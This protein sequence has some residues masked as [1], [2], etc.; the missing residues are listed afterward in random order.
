MP[1]LRLE[2]E[3][4]EGRHMSNQ[5][6]L[7]EIFPCEVDSIPNL[8]A[9]F[10]YSGEDHYQLAD[11]LLA[12]NLQTLFGGVWVAFDYWIL[13]ELHIPTEELQQAS[14]FLQHEMPQHYQNLQGIYHDAQWQPSALAQATFVV[15]GLAPHYETDIVQAINAIHNRVPKAKIERDFRLQPLVVNHTPCISISIRSTL[16]SMQNV[17]QYMT[18]LTK[19]Q[20]EIIG[21]WVKDKTSPLMG[22]VTEVAGLLTEAYR[23]YLLERTAHPIMHTLVQNAPPEDWV[24]RF[25]HETDTFDYLASTL[26]PIIRSSNA[27]DLQRFGINPKQAQSAI[28]VRPD[29]RSQLIRSASEVLKENNLI[30]RAFNSI[31]NPELFRIED[32][33]TDVMFQKNRTTVYK[34]KQ[35][36]L[37]FA[38][39]GVYKQHLRFEG[40]PIRIAAVNA[41]G[42][43]IDDF[44]EAMRRQLEKEFGFMIELIRERTVRTVSG[45]NLK[46]A[47]QVVEQENPHIVLAFFSDKQEIHDDADDPDAT[48]R[49][50]KSISLSKGI[51][52][53]LI[54]ESDVHNPDAMSAIIMAILGKTGN[55]PFVLA[56]PLRYAD[57]V[58]GIEIIRENKKDHDLIISMA[59]IYKSDG[60]FVR[61]V[62]NDV[63][64]DIDEPLPYI[65]MQ[66][67]LPMQDFSNK[68]VI[69]H[70][71]GTFHPHELDLLARWAQTLE[72][73]FYPVEI[74]PYDNPRIYGLAG[75]KVVQPQ[76]GKM[77]LLSETEALVM[78]TA[79]IESMTPQP[80][81]ILSL[82]ETLPIKQATQSV[83][84]WSLLHYGMTQPARFPVTIQ[85]T[86]E[87]AQWFSKGELPDTKESDVPFWL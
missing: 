6:L 55:S 65:I 80:L 11:P 60:E 32:I 13:T 71:L 77:F 27:D 16:L 70:R 10:P 49:Y 63:E 29:V 73:N 23:E 45:R 53:H 44:I 61:Y 38:K 15:C 22:E 87:I 74:H 9:Y 52:T 66:T 14:A 4:I 59:R 12:A 31:H 67:L 28:E 7:V 57:Y 43:K 36:A 25:Q 37:D 50:L 19:P 26:D 3:I 42:E 35:I 48:Y 17:S 34:P 40:K 30:G 76:W 5:A 72:T 83:L 85:Y 84:S 18:T 54:R 1:I 62:L 33:E 78:T 20:K 41:M 81:R 75:K 58:V 86:D 47:M 2:P 69:L 56:E 21:L 39:R 82:L 51:A 46:S 64:V 79:P 8:V 68:R 24:V